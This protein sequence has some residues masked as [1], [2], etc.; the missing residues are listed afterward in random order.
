[1]QELCSEEFIST[2]IA[3]DLMH[4]GWDIAI[5]FYYE[6]KKVRS[7]YIWSRRT[8]YKGSSILNVV[9]TS[10]PLDCCGCLDWSQIVQKRPITTAPGI[11]V[12]NVSWWSKAP[13]LDSFLCLAFL[14][15]HF[16]LIN[17]ARSIWK[18]R[19]PFPHP[20]VLHQY[21]CSPHAS[22]VCIFPIVFPSGFRIW[23]KVMCFISNHTIC[24]NLLLCLLTSL[25]PFPRL[26]FVLTEIM[27]TDGNYLPYHGCVLYN[28]RCVLA[29]TCGARRI[30]QVACD[31]GASCTWPSYVMPNRWSY[32]SCGCWATTHYQ[33]CWGPWSGEILVLCSTIA[34]AHQLCDYSVD[35]SGDCV[36]FKMVHHLNMI[37][38]PYDLNYLNKTKLIW[39]HWDFVR[40]GYCS[41]PYISS[42]VVVVAV[43]PWLALIYGIARSHVVYVSNSCSTNPC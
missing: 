4:N 23:I 18:E 40:S 38:S 42:L 34:D 36:I 37:G 16:T 22:P 35:V 17:R 28:K 6:R 3:L 10:L 33:I 19:P 32:C 41:L 21:A 8:Q 11:Q 15:I 14:R 5:E 2:S 24:M 26:S 30:E 31:L 9:A 12:S 1:M 20:I 7:L 43:V 39:R 25:L 13:F 29:A 27:F